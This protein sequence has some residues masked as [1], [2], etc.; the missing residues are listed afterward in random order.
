MGNDAE[1]LVDATNPA[2]LLTSYPHPDVKR[3]GAATDIL[4]KDHLNSNRFALRFAPASTT[5]GDYGPFGQPSTGGGSSV[6]PGTARPTSTS[7]S[8]AENGL[9]YLHA[10]YYD[11][12]LGRF[13]TP[14]TWDPIL[15]GVDINRYAYSLN[16]PVNLSDPLGHDINLAKR[17]DRRARLGRAWKPGMCA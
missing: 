3:E 1:L 4:I 2:G 10:R 8:I 14:D 16:D 12:D 15:A 9:Q 11:P 13:L 6:I 5:R 17:T 7:A